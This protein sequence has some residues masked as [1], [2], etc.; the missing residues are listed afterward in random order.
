MK[1]ILMFLTPKSE[2][3]VLKG[4]YT[5]KEA[6]SKMENHRYQ[7]FPV[8]DDEGR[9]LKTISEGDILFKI[10]HNTSLS[11]EEIGD[12]SINDIMPYRLINEIDCMAN[13]KD[14]MDSLLEHNFIPLCDDRGYFIGI[15]TRT[16]VL[17]YYADKLKLD[18]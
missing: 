9:Y 5:I 13:I 11:N 15:I 18:L 10:K 7:A 12:I 1:N 8:V 4:S 16:K 3:F 6:L 17:S 14:V 2:C